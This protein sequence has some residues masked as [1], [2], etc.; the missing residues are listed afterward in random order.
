MEKTSSESKI[1]IVV[2]VESYV[3][4][5]AQD[6]GDNITVIRRMLIIIGIDNFFCIITP[7]CVFIIN[8]QTIYN[9]CL[10]IYI[11]YVIF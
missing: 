11:I 6:S 3:E 5:S 4:V 7:L 10:L 9:L 2:P 1:G 8:I